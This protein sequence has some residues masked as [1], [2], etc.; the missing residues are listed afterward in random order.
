[1][2]SALAAQL[3]FPGLLRVKEYDGLNTHQPV[4]CTA[5]TNGIDTKLPRHFR[6]ATAE[7]CDGIGKSCA[8][9]MHRQIKFFGDGDQG[10]EFLK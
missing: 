9:Q 5:K 4:L 8:I 10:F 6:G 3:E 7:R 1:M 2:R